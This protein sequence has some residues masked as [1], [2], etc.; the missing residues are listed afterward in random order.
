MLASL[1]GSGFGIQESVVG[2]IPNAAT[3]SGSQD[4]YVRILNPESR[5]HERRR[6]E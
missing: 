5:I 6:R 3:A 2:G 4:G 1:A